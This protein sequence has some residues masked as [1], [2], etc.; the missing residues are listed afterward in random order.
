MTPKRWRTIYRIL[1]I[2]AF[3]SAAIY[4][5]GILGGVF[6]LPTQYES[7]LRYLVGISFVACIVIKL[8][9]HRAFKCPFCGESLDFRPG[10]GFLRLINAA[11]GFLR[12]VNIDHCSSCETDLHE[13]DFK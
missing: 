5:E 2:T 12:F 10:W 8:Y 6:D 11:I 4:A 9:V 3:S 1:L 13:L 7:L